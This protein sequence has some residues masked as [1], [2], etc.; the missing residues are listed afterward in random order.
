[1]SPL[2]LFAGFCFRFLLILLFLPHIHNTKPH[3]HMPHTTHTHT[4]LVH[5]SFT[6]NCKPTPW[7]RRIKRPLHDWTSPSNYLLP[8][9]G[10]PLVILP[11]RVHLRQT[12][13]HTKQGA[14]EAHLGGSVWIPLSANDLAAPRTIEPSHI[15]SNVTDLLQLLPP[16]STNE[17]YRTAKA[18]SSGKPGAKLT[19]PTTMKSV[20]HRGPIN[21]RV[22]SLPDLDSGNSNSSDGSWDQPQKRRR[23]RQ[24]GTAEGAAAV[25]LLNH[26]PLDKLIG[27]I[28]LDLFDELIEIGVGLKYKLFMVCWWLLI[29]SRTCE[30]SIKMAANMLDLFY[31]FYFILNKEILFSR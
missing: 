12:F 19:G 2:E 31:F 15:I 21:R 20:G 8:L 17:A 29:P 25:F 3:T 23:R 1:M 13:K 30:M 14:I 28:V 9:L 10:Q 6:L 16:L 18:A 26:Q 24:R 7:E 27:E 11:L 4:N 5:I 22:A